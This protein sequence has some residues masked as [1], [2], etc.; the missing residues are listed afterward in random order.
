MKLFSAIY[1]YLVYK[2][3]K[4]G[5]QLPHEERQQCEGDQLAP[6]QTLHPLQNPENS[7]AWKI[8]L[9]TAEPKWSAKVLWD[10]HL[11]IKP[12][13]VGWDSQEEATERGRAL[14]KSVYGLC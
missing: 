7:H 4:A 1:A 8:L 14:Q 13:E 3:P 2:E 5:W 10:I 12:S 9:N 11:P 6:I